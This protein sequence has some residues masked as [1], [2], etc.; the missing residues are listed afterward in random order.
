MSTINQDYATKFGF[1]DNYKPA[2]DLGPGLSADV[3][4]Q[5]SQYKQEPDW[6][7]QLR[8]KALE[9]FE[10]RPMPTW[11]ADLSQIDF[12]K[13]H[14]FVK[15][16]DKTSTSWDEVPEEI[17]TTFDRLGIPQA[18]RKFLAGV[19]SQYESEVVY[20]QLHQQW[21]DAGVEFYDMDSALKERPDLV[22]EYF[23]KLIPYT[24][25]KFAALNTAVWSGG[26]FIYI[27]KGVKVD[28][29]LQAYFR[30]NL[31]NMGQFERT[32]IIVDEGAEVHYIEGCTAPMYTTDSLHAAVVEIFVKKD[33]RCRYTTIQNWSD[34][35]YNLVTKRARTD[36]NAVMEWVDC[37]LGSKV[38]MKYPSVIL[39]GE[40]SHGEVLSL[41]WAQN[42]QV[43]DTG[44]KM[45][46]IAPN[47]SSIITSKSVCQN[48]GRTSYRGQIKMTNSTR[49]CKA[50]I[51]CD[52]L[53]FDNKSRTDTYPTNINTQPSNSIEHEA[54]VS[55]INDEQLFYLTSRGLDEEQAAQLIVGG[56]IEPIT[57]E[58]PM[59]YA[60]EL[61]ELLR[62]NM[63]G[64][65]G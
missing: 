53:I 49:N 35:V 5:I 26:S 30:I 13:I 7:L 64:S 62:M 61:N 56:F 31:K 58:L 8:L 18:E 21:Q 38:T 41:A 59:E 33:A 17:K 10:K 22:K 57:R 4:R 37:N 42:H 44:G 54:S 15:A 39:A 19:A 27:P 11:G 47:T 40:G 28:I 2:V 25:N 29:P 60:L 34:N 3:V 45:I 16:T 9:E 46:H 55:K 23:G 1:A 43:Q 51:N 36:K 52:A 20:H 65:V 24:D 63:E 48:G 12:D 6:M 50:K 32:L 14:Y